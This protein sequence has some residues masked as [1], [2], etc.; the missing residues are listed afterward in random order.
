MV[1]FVL[2]RLTPLLSAT[3][4]GSFQAVIWPEKILASVGPSRCKRFLT[5]GRLYMIDVPPS[6]HG[7]C[8]HPL[9]AVN[10]SF[11]S[12]ASLAPKSTV[13]DVSAAMPPP[14]PIGLYWS[15][16]PSASPTACCHWATSGETN[17]LPAPEMVA[18]LLAPAVPAT[19]TATSAAAATA[20]MM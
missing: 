13:R 17:V 18:S 11:V 12:G 3:I 16:M 15:S 1:I 4:A 10:W 19:T 14:D 6:A 9:H 7:I 2:G 20:L 8:S 5:P